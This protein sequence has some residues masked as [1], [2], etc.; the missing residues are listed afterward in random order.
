MVKDSIVRL[1]ELSA[2]K[3]SADAAR[4]NA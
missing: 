2:K 1:K 3:K 4:D